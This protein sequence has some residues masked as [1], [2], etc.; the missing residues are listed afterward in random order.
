MIDHAASGVLTASA[1]ARIDAFVV[2][3][4][5]AAVA[6]GVGHAFRSASDVWI[7]EVLR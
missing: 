4:S 6:V 7:T 3:T 1:G 2:Q 5:L